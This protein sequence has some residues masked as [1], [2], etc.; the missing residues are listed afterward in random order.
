LA[1]RVRDLLAAEREAVADLSH[2]LRTPLTALRLEA[3]SLAPADRRRIGSGV[4]ELERAVDRVIAEARRPA[5]GGPGSCDLVRAVRERVAFWAP[6]AEEQGRAWSLEAPADALPV[7][8]HPGDVEA[9]VDA[10][11]GNVFA[12]TP[13]GTGFRVAVG[14]A[15]GG[16]RLLVVE[17]EGG[18]LPRAH[19]V[20]RGASG[21]GSTGLGLDI[22]RST[23]EAVGGSLRLGGA[24][25]GGAR[26]EMLLPDDSSG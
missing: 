16:G 21:A 13:E 19:V 22:V 24:A 2:R 14:P 9:A 3:E 7:P 5:R 4:D 15:P 26:V 17:D 10:L 18:G 23:A 25:G 12:H 1:A 11:L 8:V 6:L 20:A